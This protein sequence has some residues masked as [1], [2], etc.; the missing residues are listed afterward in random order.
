MS[1]QAREEDAASVH[2][3]NDTRYTMSK[4]CGNERADPA[5]GS[6]PLHAAA[7]RGH[8]HVT[9]ALLAAGADPTLVDR[10][11]RKPLDLAFASA[12]GPLIRV[13]NAASTTGVAAGLGLADIARHVV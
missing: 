8:Y 9:R 6:T 1:G 11:R 10:R 7:Q 12:V 5:R 2:G 3:Y 13:L 4:P